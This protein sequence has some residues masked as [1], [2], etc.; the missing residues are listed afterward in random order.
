MSAVSA[1]NYL[2]NKDFVSLGIFVFAG[3]GFVILGIKPVLKP[4]NAVRAEKYAFTLF[5]GAAVILLY[6]IASVK[7]KLF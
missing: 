6:W 4:Q 3:V 5:F 7:M 1:L 2:M